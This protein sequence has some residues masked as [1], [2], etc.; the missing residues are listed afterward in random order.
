MAKWRNGEPANAA[1]IAEAVCY[2][3][4]NDAWGPPNFS[5]GGEA[6]GR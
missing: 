1:Q 6:A 4:N 5:T 2:K 3:A